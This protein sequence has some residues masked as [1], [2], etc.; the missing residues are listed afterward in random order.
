[1]A[2]LAVG[3]QSVIIFYSTQS[4]CHQKCEKDCI[5]VFP[6]DHRCNP[7]VEHSCSAL[8]GKGNFVINA[9]LGLCARLSD[10][11]K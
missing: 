5:K 9:A 2:S 6:C 4:G 3:K 7:W 11:V 10:S 8:N 1:M